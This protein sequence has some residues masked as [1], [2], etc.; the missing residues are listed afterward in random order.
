MNQV[1]PVD[2]GR[3]PRLA[4]ID[5][6]SDLRR[7]DD[8]EL[9]AVADELR[10]YLIE[11][12][13]HSGGHFGAGL[14]VIELTTALHYLYDTPDD[15]IVWD[16]GHQ[17]YPHKILTGRRDAIRTVTQAGG[18]SPFPKREESEYDTFG[19][20]HSSTSISAALGMAIANARAGNDR[21]VVAVI[22]DGAMTAGMAWEALG[23]AGGMDD[24]PNL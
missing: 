6:P 4:R 22:G 10:A 9:R 24:E 20:G 14:G 17:A 15:R 12:V 1:P 2:A 21:K 7:L 3:Y 19:V 8:S 16:V 13:G 23:H 18:I 11:C 5:A